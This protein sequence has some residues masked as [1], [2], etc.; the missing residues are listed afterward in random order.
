MRLLFEMPPSIRQAT[1]VETS[2]TGF[3]GVIVKPPR[4][5]GVTTA[6]RKISWEVF[7]G[8]WEGTRNFYLR[9]AIRSNRKYERREAQK[10]KP[11]L[12]GRASKIRVFQAV[13]YTMIGA[14]PC[15]ALSRAIAAASS[16]DLSASM[17]DRRSATRAKIAN[18]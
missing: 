18:S 16:R 12:R 4:S 5:F 17:R 14:L 9:E 10:K 6:R 11:G 15:P 8:A 13:A 3:V 1:V 7:G 2:A